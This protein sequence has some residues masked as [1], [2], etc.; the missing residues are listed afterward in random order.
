MTIKNE[1]IKQYGYLMTPAD[2]AKV[3]NQHPTHIRVLCRRGQLPAVQIGKRWRI[4]TEKLAAILD[5][6]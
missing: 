4:N 5:G 6:E 2:V 1:L 3:L